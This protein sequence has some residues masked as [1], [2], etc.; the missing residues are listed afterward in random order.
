MVIQTRCHRLLYP[1]KMRQTDFQFKS[2]LGDT[3]MVKYWT[4]STA[5]GGVL[6]R[7][8]VVFDLV[9]I[10]SIGRYMAILEGNLVS[11][12]LACS[13]R[14]LGFLFG[15]KNISA[16]SFNGNHGSLKN[17]PLTPLM[18]RVSVGTPYH[19]ARTVYTS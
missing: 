15:D 7:N 3:N 2:V 12:E 5:K 10:R 13:Y 8:K 18:G 11:T 17:V 19:V 1:A 9:R 6:S 14:G 16:K 4:S